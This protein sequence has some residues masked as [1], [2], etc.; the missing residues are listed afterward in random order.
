MPPLTSSGTPLSRYNSQGHDDHIDVNVE[1]NHRNRYLQLLQHF[2]DD[3]VAVRTKVAAIDQIFPNL[4]LSL[5]NGG[6]QVTL[7]LSEQDVNLVGDNLEGKENAATKLI[8][9]IIAIAF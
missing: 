7:L 3:L 1:G 8:R 2:A 4:T 5:Y 6:E 9:V